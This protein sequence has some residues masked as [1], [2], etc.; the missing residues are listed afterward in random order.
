MSNVA[1]SEMHWRAAGNE[2]L[3]MMADR[4]RSALRLNDQFGRVVDASSDD[5]PTAARIGSD[6][7]VAVLDNLRRQNDA[8]GVARR[9]LELLKQP[10]GKGN[11]QMHCD[12]DGRSDRVCTRTAPIPATGSPD[13]SSRQPGSQG[14]HLTGH[15][16]SSTAVTSDGRGSGRS[17]AGLVL[18][19]SDAHKSPSGPASLTGALPGS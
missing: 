18:T 14:L 13:D 10:H 9:L 6:E 3:V 8:H 4:L 12:S 2:V 7:F 15:P 5:G 16:T 11:M 17:A 19:P 1:P